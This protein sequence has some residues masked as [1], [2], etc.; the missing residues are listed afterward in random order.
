MTNEY[1]VLIDHQDRI[2]TLQAQADE[3]TSQIN[4]ARIVIGEAVAPTNA[5]AELQQRRKAALAD[6]HLGRGDA[7]AV[8]MI[9]SAIAVAERAMQAADALAEAA[10]AALE[11]LEPQLTK[12]QFEIAPL[13]RMVPALLHAAHV[14]NCLD[15][16]GPYRLAVQQLL[17]DAN[18]VV[19]DGKELSAIDHLL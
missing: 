13:V 4:H 17:M 16:V 18:R 14:E 2:R 1:Q 6:Q 5:V 8:R 3:L 11:I 9:E 19:V 10:A 15:A 12:L 7:T